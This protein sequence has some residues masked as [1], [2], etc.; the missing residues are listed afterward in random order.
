MLELTENARKELDSFFSSKPEEERSIRIYSAYSCSGPRLF[1]ALDKANENDAV[2]KNGDYSFCIDK[3]LLAQV[4]SVTIDLNYL[5]FDVQPEVA[6][7]MPEGGGCAS[8]SGC[9]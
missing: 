9:H 5:G 6:L 4:K 3:E 2:E 1:I 8:C 7:P